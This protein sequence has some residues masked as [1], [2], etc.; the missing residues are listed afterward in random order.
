MPFQKSKHTYLSPV[1][2]ILKN[3]QGVAY[4]KARGR[5]DATI[6]LCE[7]AESAEKAFKKVEKWRNNIDIHRSI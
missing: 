5:N 2:H 4:R 3:E 7:Y 1:D 6:S